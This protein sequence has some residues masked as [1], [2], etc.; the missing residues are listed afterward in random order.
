MSCSHARQE[1]KFS[2]GI[3]MFPWASCRHQVLFSLKRGRE[4]R[5]FEGEV[6]TQDGK[7]GLCICKR[8]KTEKSTKN[9]INHE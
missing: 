6:A 9:R 5:Y 7:T 4:I 8:K 3:E 2:F 1:H